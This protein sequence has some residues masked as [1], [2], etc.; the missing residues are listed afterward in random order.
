[1]RQLADLF[2]L[3]KDAVVSV[4]GSGGK[5]SLIGYLAQHYSQAKIL[6]TTTTK[7]AYPQ[8]RDY[9]YFYDNNYEGLGKYSGISLVGKTVTIN[10]VKKISFPTGLDIPSDFQPF[11]QVFIE[12][13]GS[14]Q[15]PLKAWGDFEP[16]ILPETTVTVGVLPLTVLGKKIGPQI[17]HRFEVFQQT[18]KFTEETVMPALLAEIISGEAGLFQKAWGERILFLNQV[19]SAEAYEKA[20][21]VVAYLPESF[22]ASCQKIIAGSVQQEEGLIL[23]EK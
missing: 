11:D 13:D 3:K 20:Q 9:D 10:G 15:L 1:M 22:K 18:F 7:M 21:Q 16:V 19:E 8:K 5:T 12:A 23:W 2:T 4:I 17:I 14:K 6:V